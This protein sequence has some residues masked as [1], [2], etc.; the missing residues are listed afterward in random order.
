MCVAIPGTVTE[1]NREENT[2][3]VDFHG[4]KVNARS[5]LVDVKCGDRVLVH[6][7]LIIQVMSGEE[8]AEIED[9]FDVIEGL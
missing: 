7:G 6:A 8:A 9:L 4:N 2:A 5:G 1:V 3:V